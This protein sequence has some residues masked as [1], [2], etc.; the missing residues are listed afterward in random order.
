MLLLIRRLKKKKCGLLITSNTARLSHRELT[1]RISGT[2][3]RNARL[4]KASKYKAPAKGHA[5]EWSLEL[6]KPIQLATLPR[7][8]SS[9]CPWQW[10]ITEIQ[11]LAKKIIYIC[12]CMYIHLPPNGCR[13]IKKCV[14]GRTREHSCNQRTT[15]VLCYHFLNLFRQR[16]SLH[17]KL[18]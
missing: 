4:K 10:L 1:G 14:W 18:R 16:L 13:E 7:S 11:R 3:K 15:P 12:L 6:G 8:Q 17:L 9:K 5:E 2:P